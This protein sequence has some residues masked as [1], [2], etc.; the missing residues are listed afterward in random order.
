MQLQIN[1]CLNWCTKGTKE[2]ETLPRQ[3]LHGLMWRLFSR[4]ACSCSWR[5][6]SDDTHATAICRL[7]ENAFCANV[8]TL[9]QPYALVQFSADCRL[10]E[11]MVSGAT[12]WSWGPS[13]CSCWTYGHMWFA[14]SAGLHSLY[15]EVFC[16]LLGK[17]KST[18]CGVKSPV[19][20]RRW[21]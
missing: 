9:L 15:R 20:A 3:Q 7:R 6:L 2:L 14:M 8:S 4:P 19:T 16:Y 10:L 12:G 11:M 5:A 17:I 13:A 18:D 1:Q 21:L